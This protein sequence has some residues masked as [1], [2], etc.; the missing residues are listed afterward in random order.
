MRINYL[1]TVQKLKF[2]EREVVMSRQLFDFYVCV[3]AVVGRRCA[4]D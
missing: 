1:V 4:E 3:F 2:F